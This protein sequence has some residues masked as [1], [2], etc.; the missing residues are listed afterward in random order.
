MVDM[1]AFD[2]QGVLVE[3]KMQDLVRGYMAAFAEFVAQQR[4]WQ[5]S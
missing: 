3:T 1:E 4:R 5:V 2:Q